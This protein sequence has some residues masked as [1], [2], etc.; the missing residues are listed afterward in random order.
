MSGNM[1]IV[2]SEMTKGGVPKG[3]ALTSAMST[4]KINNALASVTEETG[5]SKEKESSEGED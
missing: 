1:R 3:K 2:M 4:N 5:E